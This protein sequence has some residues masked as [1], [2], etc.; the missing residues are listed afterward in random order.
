MEQLCDATWWIEILDTTPSVLRAPYIALFRLPGLSWM[1]WWP[2]YL[3]LCLWWPCFILPK[4]GTYSDI[5][6]EKEKA[7]LKLWISWKYRKWDHFTFFFYCGLDTPP[8]TYPLSKCSSAQYRIVL[9]RHNVVPQI[10]R[11]YSSWVM[12]TLCVLISN[13]LPFPEYGIYL[14]LHCSCLA[15]R[16]VNGSTLIGR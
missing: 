3:F 15:G 2:G 7:N 5:W 14:R 13:T 9:Y 6:S 4:A 12:E 16:L 8:V 11:A 1:P 10:S